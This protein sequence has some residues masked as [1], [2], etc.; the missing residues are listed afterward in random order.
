MVKFTG[1]YAI[2]VQNRNLLKYTTGKLY[3]A[4][5]LDSVELEASNVCY[6]YYCI[7][8]IPRQQGVTP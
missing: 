8:L 3:L 4:A 1:V 7:L 2:F 6:E 5:I